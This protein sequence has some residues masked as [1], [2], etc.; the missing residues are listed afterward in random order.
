MKLTLGKTVRLEKDV[1]EN[2]KY[3]R[4]LRYIWVRKNELNE[5]CNGAL[6]KGG[7]ILINDCLIRLGYAKTLTIPPDIKYAQILRA[8]QI[9]AIKNKRGLW[10]NCVNF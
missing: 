4:L 5:N 8:S 9:S 1:S 6:E 10:N 7:F 3:H 2:D